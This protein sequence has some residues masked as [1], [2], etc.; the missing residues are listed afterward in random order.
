[1]C[2][3]EGGG[4]CGSAFGRSNVLLRS[5][6]GFSWKLTQ[7]CELNGSR[8]LCRSVLETRAQS[9]SVVSVCRSYPGA[10]YARETGTKAD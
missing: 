9:V 8:V 6:A 5:D 3:S 7:L 4:S 1:M 2:R 10:V